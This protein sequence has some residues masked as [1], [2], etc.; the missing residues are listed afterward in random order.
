MPESRGGGGK[1]EE[2]P[3]DDVEE[4]VE[5]VCVEIFIGRGRGEEQVEEFED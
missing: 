2:I 3:E 5:V 1:V 4:D